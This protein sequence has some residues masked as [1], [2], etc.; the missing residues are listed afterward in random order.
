MSARRCSQL[1]SSSSV[2]RGR[3][4]V[5]PAPPRS[6]RRAAGQDRARAPPWPAPGTGRPGAPDRPRPRHRRSASATSAAMAKASR[7]LPTPPGPVRVSSGTASSSSSPRPEQRSASRPMSRVRGIGGVP[8]RVVC[9][10]TAMGA[11]PQGTER[12]VRMEALL[13]RRWGPGWGH[14]GQEEDECAGPCPF[15]ALV[16]AEIGPMPAAEPE[17]GDIAREPAILLISFPAIAVSILRYLQRSLYDRDSLAATV[18]PRPS[19][20]KTYDSW[21]PDSDYQVIHDVVAPRR[22]RSTPSIA[23]AATAQTPAI[24]HSTGS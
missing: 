22:C 23:P 24:A 8:R 13:Y 4:A 1:S 6:G 18:A 14:R 2:C 21:E 12:L 10:S 20:N 17:T 5:E 3:R 7:V 9:A 16:D 15:R 19:R 11:H